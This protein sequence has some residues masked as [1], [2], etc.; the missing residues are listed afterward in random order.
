M[1]SLPIGGFMP[2]PLAMMIPFMATQSMVMGQA[3]GMGFQYGKRKIS[4]MS[5]EEFNKTTMEAIASEMFASYEKI[6]PNLKTQMAD[7]QGLQNFIIAKLLDMPRDLISDFFNSITG[8]QTS[9]TGEPVHTEEEIKTFTEETAGK[10]LSPEEQQSTVSPTDPDITT[11]TVITKSQT[12]L[13]S[14][15]NIDKNEKFLD[16]LV[17]LHRI[18][19][20]LANSNG[21]IYLGVTYTGA[22]ATKRRDTLLLQKRAQIDVVSRLRVAYHQT[23]GVWY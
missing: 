8:Q 2:I 13:D 1:V 6:I 18:F 12:Q 9:Q 22:Q 20:A 11:G 23:Y 7:N 14:E 19:M 5:N 16:E 10:F 4:A 3:F 21:G 15:S 17:S